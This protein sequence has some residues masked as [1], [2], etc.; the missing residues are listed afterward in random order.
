MPDGNITH[1]SFLESADP[2]HP[3]IEVK[4][5]C[6]KLF[7]I[8]DKDDAGL[9]KDGTP[10]R[11]YTKKQQRHQKLKDVLNERYYCL[12]CREIENALS[13]DVLKKVVQ[14]YEGGEEPL[15]FKDFD[16]KAYKDKYLGAFIESNIEGI[17]RSYKSQ[18][19]TIKDKVNFAKKAVAHINSTEDLS[20]EALNLT[21]KLYK[22]IKE[23]NK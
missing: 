14:G 10:D 4:R 9:K 18:S 5:L 15:Q 6:G 11:R 21:E 8:T 19:G 16:Y 17:T 2:N 20:E 12:D 3:N 22:F 23:Q 13:P 1:W 7:L